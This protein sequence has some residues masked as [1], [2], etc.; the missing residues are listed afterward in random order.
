[1]QADLDDETFI[2]NLIGAM[3]DDQQLEDSIES[4]TVKDKV[5]CYP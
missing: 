3:E 2:K 5:K 4:Q 1:M